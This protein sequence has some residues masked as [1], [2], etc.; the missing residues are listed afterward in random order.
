MRL[1]RVAA[2]LVVCVVVA[3]IGVYVAAQVAV[4]KTS[5]ETPGDS[6][7]PVAI[8]LGASVKPDGTPSDVLA[9]RLRVAIA[10]YEDGRVDKVLASGDHGT[11]GYDEVNAMKDFLLAHNVAAEDIFLDHAGFDTYDTMYRAR[12]VFGISSAFVAT[13]SFHLPRALYIGEQLGMTLYAAPA[14]LQPYVKADV[15]AVRERFANVKAFVDVV[16]RA[17]SSYGGESVDI[18]GD[19]RATW[20]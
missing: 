2:A 5:L 16:M 17:K 6:T 4:G 1:M 8:V 15:F 18:T 9:D 19:G 10:L 13:Q 12:H 20:D 14:D 7:A 3:M 11:V